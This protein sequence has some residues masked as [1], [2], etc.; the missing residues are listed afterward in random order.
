MRPVPTPS[1]TTVPPGCE[2]FLDVER[3]V[4]DDARAPRVVEP[5][6]RVVVA[7]AG[8]PRHPR[9]LGRVV[10]ERL[11]CEA[12]VDGLDLEAGDID[13]P[14]PFGLRRPPQLDG[15]LRA[16][17]A[18]SGQVDAVIRR[19]VTHLF[20]EACVAERDALRVVSRREER[21]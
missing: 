1:S 3:D 17:L 14:F 19:S 7:H 12:A 9:E 4:L 11:A 15:P 6:D 18:P 2:R 13:E 16:V 20:P 21:D 5:R 8:L 10:F